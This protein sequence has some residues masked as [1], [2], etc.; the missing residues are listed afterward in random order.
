MFFMICPVVC[1]AV[2]IG[3]FAS[4]QNE[5]LYCGQTFCQVKLTET[6]NRDCEEAYG[7]SFI[8][9]VLCFILHIFGAVFAIARH[10]FGEWTL[11]DVEGEDLAE[12]T[13]RVNVEHTVKRMRAQTLAAEKEEE[14]KRKEQEEISSQT[15]RRAR[16]RST[17]IP[18]VKGGNNTITGRESRSMSEVQPH[19]LQNNNHNHNH[20]YENDPYNYSSKPPTA[21]EQFQMQIQNQQNEQNQQQQFQATDWVFDENSGF[22]WS[23]T[24]YMFRDPASLHLYDPKIEKWFDVD[25]SI[26]YDG[27]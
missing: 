14:R 1:W 22:E 7:Y 8:L 2:A 5:E 27:Q 12:T 21:A 26:W 15:T 17:I 13:R 6:G 9:A 10:C 11:E 18:L 4:W 25:L 23:E 19:Q 24:L 16:G 3:R 20:N